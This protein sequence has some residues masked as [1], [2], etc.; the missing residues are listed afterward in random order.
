MQE[1]SELK[2]IS[3]ATLQ[4]LCEI[5]LSK[6]IKASLKAE[7][8]IYK[9]VIDPFSAVFDSMRQEIT[10]DAWLEQE[11]ARQLQ[12]TLQNDVGEFHQNVVGSIKDWE[13]LLVGKS[14]DLRCRGKKIIAEIK[15]KHNTM[16]SSGHLAT[17][18]K[19][20]RHLDY[21]ESYKG[22]TAYCVYVIPKSPKPLDGYYHPSERGTARPK[23]EDIKKIDGKSFYAL[24]TGDEDALQ[25]L[26]LR[27]PFIIGKII[28]KPFQK[29]VNSE[30]FI[31]LFTRAYKEKNK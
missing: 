21:D 18:D 28:N 13:N 23:R 11:K 27:L 30:T 14:I 31:D 29:V 7:H 6:A 24:A 12:K 16:N 19:L 20:S 25:K 26:Y 3:D 15:N 1:T 4:Q 22:Y 10:L 5:V 17:Y 8:E 9:N 2:F